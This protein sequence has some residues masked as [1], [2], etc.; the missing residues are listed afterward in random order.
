MGLPP[1]NAQQSS[2]CPASPHPPS[3]APNTPTP[4]ITY[5]P[6]IATVAAHAFQMAPQ[7][8]SNTAHM[9]THMQP[10]FTLVC[11]PCSTLLD[12]LVCMRKQP[13]PQKRAQRTMGS[14]TA[15]LSTIHR[16]TWQ[17]QLPSTPGGPQTHNA[18]A[19]LSAPPLTHAQVD[20]RA[21]TGHAS[22]PG[23]SLSALQPCPLKTEPPQ[24]IAFKSDTP[25]ETPL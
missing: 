20:T 16:S 25:G 8:P 24:L 2:L 9:C 7:T 1:I 11:L 10:S 13:C 15:A 19:G 4:T 12:L 18:L 5:T 21:H 3:A 6:S 22:Q 14:C 23:T 17:S